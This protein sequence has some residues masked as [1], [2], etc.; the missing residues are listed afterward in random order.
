[1]IGVWFIIQLFN[2][3]GAVAEVQGGGVA[4]VAHVGGFIFGAITARPF[5]CF[6]RGN[7]WEA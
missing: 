1:L 6:L 3:V 2:Q 4:Y 5:E 7:E